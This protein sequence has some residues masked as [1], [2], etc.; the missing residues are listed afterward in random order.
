[1]HFGTGQLVVTEV[2]FSQGVQQGQVVSA[3]FGNR[4]VKQH[5]G[6]GS[7]GQA[8]GNTLQQIVVHVE[9]VQLLQALKDT[10]S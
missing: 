6:L 7:S 4:V 1:M 8:P 2:E 9:S 3:N 5:Y 10:Q